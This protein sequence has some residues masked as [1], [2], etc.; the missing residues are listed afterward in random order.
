MFIA[1][2]HYQWHLG[3]P[4]PFYDCIDE[5]HEFGLQFNDERLK[6]IDTF[7]ADGDEYVFI[8]KNM[9]NVRYNT[10][11]DFCTWYGDEAKFIIRNLPQMW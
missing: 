2:N 1:G 8:V 10:K 3:T 9:P 6:P 4:H 7:W 11:N 5:D